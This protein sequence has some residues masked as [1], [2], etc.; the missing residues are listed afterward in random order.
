MKEILKKIH[1]FIDKADFEEAHCIINRRLRETITMQERSALEDLK[2]FMNDM[3]KIVDEMIE[4]DKREG[5]KCYKRLGCT[6]MRPY[7]EGEDLS[8]MKIS[9]SEADKLNGSPKPGDMI[10]RNRDNHDDKWL[11]SKS[12]FEKNMDQNPD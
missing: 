4:E 5:W 7:I 12:Y 3:D 8:G 1:S 11:V 9:I 10:A 6:E 2:I